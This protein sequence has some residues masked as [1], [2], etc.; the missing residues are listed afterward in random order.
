[1]K[2]TNK[3]FDFI[4]RRSLYFI[5]LLL[6][7]FTTS[8]SKSEYNVPISPISV[9]STDLDLDFDNDLIIGHKVVWGYTNKSMSILQNVDSGI[10]HIQ[11]TSKSFCGTQQNIFA[12]HIDTDDYP[13]IVTFYSDFSSGSAE[14]FVRIYYNEDGE[15]YYYNDFILNSSQT[16]IS[17][18]YGDFNGDSY[19]DLSV[20]SNLGQFWGVLYND[21]TGNFSE[22]TYYSISDYSPSDIACADLNNDGRDDIVIGGK[23]EIFFSTETGF[24]S[25][26]FNT[27]TDDI[28][29][30]D[31]D[32]DGDIDIIGG[33]QPMPSNYY[34]LTFIENLGDENFNI[35]PFYTFQPVCNGLTVSDFD[36]DSLPDLLLH[37]QDVQN[38][39][40][41][42]NKGDFELSEPQ[43]IPLVNYG[44]SKRR[45]AC[46]DFDGNG[47][48]DIAT[49]RSWGAPLPANVNILF[50]DG[51]GNFLENPITNI[52]IQNSK[53]QTQNLRCY[54][55]PF[56]SEI[57]ISYQIKESSIV[58][59]SFYSHTGEL[60]TTIIHQ[61]QENGNYIKKWDG[62]DN[63]GKLCKSGLYIA[64]LEINGAIK[65]TVKLFYLIPH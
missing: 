54:P 49:I 61:K 11:D 45:S 51:N 35:L 42:Y 58:D 26:Y 14:R 53:L 9:F 2:S 27:I 1:M 57:N 19:I 62:S 10:F 5:V 4:I 37:T 15:F 43:F 24:Q 48:N 32:N 7:A 25:L 46:G 17:I 3:I 16:F 41:Y 28:K 23:T 22:P 39:L 36:N 44:E 38:L 47:Y 55:N 30:V 63:G 65:E 56:H 13:D 20:I 12:C 50:N 60:I 21:G 6:I 33:H 8:D 40:I 31:F 52:K 64:A 34:Q 18:N 59:I 29:T